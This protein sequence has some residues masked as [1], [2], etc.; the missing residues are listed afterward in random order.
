MRQFGF[1]IVSFTE[2]Q[3]TVSI[4]TDR[5]EAKISE[6]VTGFLCFF[7]LGLQSNKCI[8]Q[9]KKKKHKGFQS[10]NGLSS[11]I[12]PNFSPEAQACTA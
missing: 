4:S 10:L 7:W 6:M 11:T 5:E 8:L 3:L 1:Q 2:V 9:Q 12:I